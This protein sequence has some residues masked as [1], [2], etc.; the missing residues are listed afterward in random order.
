MKIIKVKTCQECPYLS[1]IYESDLFFT[2]PI[3]SCS[4]CC[5]LLS[6]VT[7]DIKTMNNVRSH[8]C[9]LEEINE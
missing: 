3:P 6:I 9:T 4:Y 2:K 8:L 7:V 5:K 1:E